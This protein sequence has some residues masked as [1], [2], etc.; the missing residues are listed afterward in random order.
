VRYDRSTWSEWPRRV[1]GL[2]LAAV[3]VVVAAAIAVFGFDESRSP[4]RAAVQSTPTPTVVPPTA[5]RGSSKG[6][7]SGPGVDQP[8]VLM[9]F[10]P[11][12]DGGFDV[13]EHVILRS[14]VSRVD[15]VP[16]S[17]AA[18]GA[19][20]A[21]THPQIVDLQIQGDDA[22]PLGRNIPARPMTRAT[23]VPLGG[24]TSTLVLRYQLAGTSVRSIPSRAGRALAYVRPITAGF[25]STLPVQVAAGGSGTLN[26]TCPALPADALACAAGTAPD[27]HTRSAL[28]D[29]ASTVVVQLDLP[30]P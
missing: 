27:L 25:D 29:S 13:A 17:H 23:S 21:D 12:A 15:F 19:A 7:T 3:L 1:I 20:F 24:A 2:S 16:P 6:I 11:R 8:G 18:A 26:L 9:E 10:S 30:E 14:R 5:E 22:Q 28:R 4:S